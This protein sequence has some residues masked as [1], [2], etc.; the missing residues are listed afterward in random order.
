MEPDLECQ[1]IYYFPDKKMFDLAFQKYKKRVYFDRRISNKD[2]LKYLVYFLYYK[3]NNDINVIYKYDYY[4]FHLFS[5]INKMT[6]DIPSF[7]PPSHPFLDFKYLPYYMTFLIKIFKIY[8][9]LHIQNIILEKISYAFNCSLDH[10]YTSN[11]I[12][13]IFS[14]G[15]FNTYFIKLIKDYFITYQSEKQLKQ[16]IIT[17]YKEYSYIRHAWI[18]AVINITIF[19]SKLII[20]KNN[21]KR[22]K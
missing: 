4:I 19:N 6:E 13:Y 10:H 9:K 18:C 14:A 2:K 7:N 8:T 3:Y 17:Q 20:C 21:S 12:F 15:L 5:D 11:H 16:T 22:K 1:K